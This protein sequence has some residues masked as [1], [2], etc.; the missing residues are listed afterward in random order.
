MICLMAFYATVWMSRLITKML[1]LTTQ[2]HY[3]GAASLL[4]HIPVFLLPKYLRL[5]A[6]L[7]TFPSNISSYQ[8]VQLHIAACKKI[9][10]SPVRVILIAFLILFESVAPFKK[11]NYKS[12]A[13]ILNKSARLVTSN[14]L[15]WRN[16]GDLTAIKKP[17]IAAGLNFVLKTL[18]LHNDVS[19]GEGDMP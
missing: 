17:H 9:A 18:Y 14:I 11:V 16:N 1:Y 15:C 2:L 7:N 12:H 4:H 6:V 19:C 8:L 10:P 5:N 13:V 3:W